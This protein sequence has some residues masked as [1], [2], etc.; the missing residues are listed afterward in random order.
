MREKLHL[1]DD[2]KWKQW[3]HGPTFAPYWKR[4]WEGTKENRPSPAYYR[5]DTLKNVQ[6]IM[7]S[8][9]NE[10]VTNSDI[11]GWTFAHHKASFMYHVVDQ[12]FN[13]A[14]AIFKTLELPKQEAEALVWELLNIAIH[15]YELM[16][17]ELIPESDN[18]FEL[19][20]LAMANGKGLEDLA[21]LVLRK[22]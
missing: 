3:V 16:E 7:R 21:E 1:K 9:E 8:C 15:L 5:R 13:S 17:I 14:Q 11:T 19:E 4:F 18:E 10:L 2:E 22:A 20:R 12:N 6:E